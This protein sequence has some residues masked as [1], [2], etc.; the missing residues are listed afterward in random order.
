MSETVCALYYEDY[1]CLALIALHCRHVHTHSAATLRKN[2]AE[3][4]TREDVQYDLLNYLF[5]DN[6]DVFT[7][8][9]PIY[10]Q[11]HPVE[12]L[13]RLTFRSLY[14]NSLLWSG[15]LSGVVKDAMIGNRDF[16]LEFAKIALLVNV[17]RINTTMACETLRSSMAKDYSIRLQSSQI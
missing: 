8:P 3:P 17:G 10:K 6:S 7:D 12:P 16:A 13:P 14:I 2:D 1:M 5:A 11:E 15:K 9:S 4:L